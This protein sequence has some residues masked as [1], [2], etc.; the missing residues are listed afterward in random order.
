MHNLIEKYIKNQL[1]ENKINIK[2]DDI[3]L[4]NWRS[5][6]FENSKEKEIIN[7]ISS[8]FYFIN[9]KEAIDFLEKVCLNLNLNLEEIKKNNDIYMKDDDDFFLSI[10]ILK[11]F[12]YYSPIYR[13]EFGDYKNSDKI[14]DICV[15]LYK[16]YCIYNN[17]RTD[18]IKKIRIFFFKTIVSL[19]ENINKNN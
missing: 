4:S 18:N 10:F 19:I 5:K 16:K 2:Y 9:N 17:I 1:I 15:E 14:L 8:F 12:S 6:I 11:A 13:N 7:S 3:F